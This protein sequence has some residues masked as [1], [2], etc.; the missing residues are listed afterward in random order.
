[1]LPEFLRFAEAYYLMIYAALVI[2][3]MVVCPS[4]LLGLLSRAIAAIR[5]REPAERGD[6]KEGAQL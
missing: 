2:F 1:M 6:L 4:G 3:L 5:S